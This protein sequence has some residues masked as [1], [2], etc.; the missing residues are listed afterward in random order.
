MAN[1]IAGGNIAN[2]PSILAVAGDVL[3]NNIDRRAFS[4]QNVGT[5]P[6]FVRLATG[7]SSTVFHA[8]LKGGTADSDGTGGSFAMTNGLVYT[9]VVSVA[10]TSPKF[11]VMEI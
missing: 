3:T 6:L 4:I 9:G 2:T 7:A 11:V 10:G 1:I 5:N 8:V